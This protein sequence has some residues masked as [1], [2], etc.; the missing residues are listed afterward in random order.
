MGTFIDTQSDLAD[1]FADT[2]SNHSEFEQQQIVE[3][4]VFR[5][6]CPAWD[7][8][9]EEWLEDAVPDACDE[10]ISVAGGQPSND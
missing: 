2:C 6:D 3:I 7:A 8:D 9:W 1:Y 5:D 10:V 4:L